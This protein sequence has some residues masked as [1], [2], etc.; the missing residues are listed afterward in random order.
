MIA[1]DDP[2]NSVVDPEGRV[3]GMEGLYVVDGSVLPRSSRVNPSLS[4]YGWGLRVA[5]RLAQ[6]AER[7]SDTPIVAPTHPQPALMAVNRRA[8]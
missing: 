5:D 4:I 1:G 8:T 7:Q 3:H 2:A 6:R